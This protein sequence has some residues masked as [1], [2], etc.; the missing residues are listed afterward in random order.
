MLGFIN[1]ALFLNNS[2][3]ASGQVPV[4]AGP[5]A[6]PVWT[7][8]SSGGATLT[9]TTNELIKYSSS[10]SGIGTGVFNASGSDLTLGAA[11]TAGGVR[12]ILVAGS[13]TDIG[14]QFTQKGAGQIA[15]VKSGV[16]TAYFSYSTNK[17]TLFGGAPNNTTPHTFEL[18]TP[19]GTPGAALTGN[20]V[21][22]TGTPDVSGNN[23]SGNIY[24]N[25][26]LPNG[27]GVGGNI[28]LFSTSIANFQGARKALIISNVSAEPSA[29]IADSIAIYSVDVSSNTTLGIR[30]ETA[31]I[32]DAAAAST[33]ALKVK[34]N[35]T[36]YFIMLHT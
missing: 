3:G 27:T 29:A 18:T 10:T 33:H 25:P 19:N 4:S 5:N 28:A 15:F 31:V 20:L 24:M 16:S 23:N 13:A 12:E 36:E 11:A 30:T 32:T 22:T 6:S 2:A 1:S 26:G 34:I 9:G 35:G 8:L 14:L 7:T 21:I 17:V